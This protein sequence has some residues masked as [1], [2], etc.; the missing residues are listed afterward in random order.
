MIPDTTGRSCGG[1]CAP[2]Q[3]LYDFQRGNLNFDLANLE[4]G[5]SW[6]RKLERLM[7]YFEEDTQIRDILITGGDALMNSDRTLARILGAVLRMA[8][9]KRDANRQ[10]ADG[11]KYAELQRVRLGTRL[12]AN[13]PYRVTP[14]LVEVLAAFR[15]KAVKV[16]VRQFMIQTH[17]ETAMEVTPEAQQ[18]VGRLL[19]AGWMVTNQQVFTAS[20]SRRGHTAR[21]RQALNDIGVLSYYTFT[22]KGFMES[23]ETFATNARAMQEQTE[24]KAAGM[25]PAALWDK[26]RKLPEHVED[27]LET[28]SDLRAEAGLPF[29]A[30]DRNVLNLPGLGK[31][32]TFRT[33][34]ITRDGRRILEF[35]HDLT[36]SHSPMVEQMPKVAIIESKSIS[37]YLS[38]LAG[39]GEDPG[40]YET[41]W[42]YSLGVTE[43]RMP[44]Y[45]YPRFGFKATTRLSNIRLP[46]RTA[47]TAEE[48]SRGRP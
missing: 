39:M 32:L 19:S 43:P 22:V 25:L 20:A 29:L 23:R 44:I 1:L 5:E 42:G 21:L 27:L 12:P 28:V 31:S 17:F 16:G 11:E 33:I 36:R 3:R 15:E 37:E 9:R 40:E 10:Y 34:G 13:L 6:P 45:D 41:I 18:A 38:Q 14:E 47:R 2:C 8:T 26:L 4:P 7:K 48:R 30:T 46:R 24:E 35:D